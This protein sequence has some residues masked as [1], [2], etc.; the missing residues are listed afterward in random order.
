MKKL[1]ASVMLSALVLVGCGKKGPENEKQAFTDATV[2][3]TCM[4]FQSDDISDPS[5]EQKT[6]DIFAKY[7]F[8]VDDNEAMK[9]IAAKYKTDADVQAAVSKALE[10]CAG[11]LMDSLDSDASEEGILE[12]TGGETTDEAAVTEEDAVTKEEAETKSE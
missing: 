8:P 11:D 12:P 6:K 4:I 9:E 5:L 10:T 7:D 3:V 2:E 1:I